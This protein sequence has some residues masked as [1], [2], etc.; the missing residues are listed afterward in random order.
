MDA[1]K[2][3]L[4]SLS[5]S[6]ESNSIM[7]WVVR[8]VLL[9]YAGLVASNLPENIA[10]LSD[11]VVVRLVMVL[12]V[13]GLSLYDPPSAILLAVAVVITIQTSNKYHISNVGTS[14]INQASEQQ[15]VLQQV[16]QQQQQQQQATPQQQQQMAQQQQQQMAQQQQENFEN[17]SAEEDQ[18][19]YSSEF[20][21]SNQLISAQTNQVREDNQETEI[22]TWQNELG[23]QGL[24]Q[25]S[26]YNIVSDHGA[27]LHLSGANR[28]PFSSSC[29]TENC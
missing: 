16:V 27:P 13:L 23:P 25:P 19:P 8:V 15:A 20:T 26:G 3:P 7:C 10:K 1:I 24:A 22:R 17:M 4:K 6:C 29:P 5:K 28:S 2:S 21:D 18:Q 14:A 11:N 12:L 9:L